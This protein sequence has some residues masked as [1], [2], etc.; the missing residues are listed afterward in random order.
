MQTM[1]KILTMTLDNGLTHAEQSALWGADF[2][3]VSVPGYGEVLDGIRRHLPDLVVLDG[4]ENSCREQAEA[5]IGHVRQEKEIKE[6]SLAVLTSLDISPSEEQRLISAGANIIIPLPS[7][8]KLWNVKLE[9]LVSIPTRHRFRVPVQI[10]AWTKVDGYDDLVQGVALN[11]SM[12]GMLLQLPV[13]LLPD[14]KFDLIFRLPGDSRPLSAVGRIVWRNRASHKYG[15]EFLVCRDDAQER[16]V[17]FLEET[18][19]VYETARKIGKLPLENVCRETTW[20]VLLRTS[21]ARKKAIMDAVCDCIIAVDHEDRILEFNQ[22]AETTFGYSKNDILLHRTLDKLLPDELCKDLRTQL[23]E[24]VAAGG[25]SHSEKIETQGR[26]ADGTEFP[27]EISAHAICFE[28]EPLLVL[29]LKDI[30]E[31]KRAEAERIRLE[32]NIRQGQKMETVG[33]LA[34]GIAHDYNNMLSVIFG[35]TE[36]AKMKLPPTD[37]LQEDLGHILKAAKRSRDI[38]RQLLTFARKQTI[39]P[40]VI[41]LNAGVEQTLAMLRQLLGE[42]IVLAWYPE[43]ELWPVEIDP[44][45]PEQILA[46]LCVNARD[47][48]LDVGK[49]T[50]RTNNIRFDAEDCCGTP[51]LQPGEFVMLAVSDD[52]CG[53]DQATLARIFEPFYTTKQVGEGTGLGLATVYGSVKQSN[54]FISAHSEPD[55]GTTFKIYLP[56]YLGQDTIEQKAVAGE[57]EIFK[58]RRE[59]IL[60]V[61][62]EAAILQ[63]TTTMLEELNYEVLAAVSPYEALALVKTR[64]KEIDLLITDV[65]MP[66]MNGRQLADRLKLIQP[67]LKCLFMSGYTENSISRHGVPAE[68]LLFIRKPFSRDNFSFQVWRALDGQV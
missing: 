57:R 54:G 4:I 11:I 62:D 47:A 25:T 56:R 27:I 29:S 18:R 63:L 65:V 12:G 40:K 42:N 30:S 49:L 46:N 60:V 23:F 32:E 50:I 1:R 14:G 61:E 37:P 68:D 5:I 7:D 55:Q 17:R 35:Y 2:E 41:D 31:R 13:K 43:E 15:I 48:I 44:S 6:I 20:E 24:F 22:A 16:L 33:R 59:T 3:R 34:G 36:L 28:R 9:R 53:M 52:G 8:P 26:R 67:G 58:G 51:D 45:Q 10:L 21:E 66:E 38:T 19:D 64:H 39:D